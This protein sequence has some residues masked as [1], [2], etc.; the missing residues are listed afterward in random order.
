MIDQQFDQLLHFLDNET[1]NSGSEFLERF[2]DLKEK[3]DVD[4]LHSILKPYFLRRMKGDVE[5]DLPSR[6][7]IVIDVEMTVLQKKL[8]K[9]VYERNTKFLIQKTTMPSLM[10][11][12]M[13]LRK[14]CNHPYLLRMILVHSCSLVLI[15]SI[16]SMRVLTVPFRH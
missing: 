15:S 16:A 6:Q 13:Q 7:E 10:N 14:C 11:I 8:Y 2:G 4:E 3:K 9:A 1:F 5:K 12:G